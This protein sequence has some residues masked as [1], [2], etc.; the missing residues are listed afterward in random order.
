MYEDAQECIS[1][2]RFGQAEKIL[3]EILSRKVDEWQATLRLLELY[4]LTEKYADFEAMYTSLPSDLRELSP[5][6]WSKIESLHQR[7][8][9]EKAI[10]FQDEP[11]AT[12]EDLKVL[13]KVTEGQAVKSKDE[14]VDLG[15]S[16]ALSLEGESAPIN[17]T[18]NDSI[19]IEALPVRDEPAPVTKA[20]IALAKAYID[21]G[22][23][24]E[25]KTILLQLKKDAV[26]EQAAII[27]NLLES[28]S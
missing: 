14:F 11:A 5:R 8:D 17:E 7:V 22:E 1:Y 3:K 4:V 26:G 20:Q 25:A 12:Q 10:H 19:N 9:N 6:V 16:Y 15:K 27:D 23:Y 18:S 28:L 24:A 13:P 21:M 2:E